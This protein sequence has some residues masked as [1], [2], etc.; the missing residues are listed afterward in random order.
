[1]IYRSN[2]DLVVSIFPN[3]LSFYCR[4]SIYIPVLADNFVRKC[5]RKHC[6]PAEFISIP[7][8]MLASYSFRKRNIINALK[9]RTNNAGK[10]CA[11]VNNRRYFICSQSIAY[12]K[13][14]QP[15]LVDSSLVSFLPRHQQNPE[16]SRVTRRAFNSP[17]P[18]APTTHF[19][20]RATQSQSIVFWGN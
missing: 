5:Q 15:S 11:C 19:C 1:M 13:S 8:K 18:P 6:L 4:T 17:L 16:H 14:P 12:G 3:V 9:F 7:V 20:D 2:I 10:P